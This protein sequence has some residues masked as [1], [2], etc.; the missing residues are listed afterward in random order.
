VVL[1]PGEVIE[2]E[3]IEKQ[4]DDA[5]IDATWN[6]WNTLGDRLYEESRKLKIEEN[7]EKLRKK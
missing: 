6:E 1:F 5:Y 2:S 4:I 3:N 7:L